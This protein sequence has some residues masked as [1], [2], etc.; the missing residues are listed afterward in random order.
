MVYQL[1]CETL[2]GDKTYGERT[3]GSCR[4]LWKVQ[5][6]GLY[7][8]P[9]GEWTLAVMVFL[10]NGSNTL[11]DS[12]VGGTFKLA[13]FRNRGLVRFQSSSE[14]GVLGTRESSSDGCDL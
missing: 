8:L 13:P 2:I 7:L 9:D 1:L 14:G 6:L 4:E 12:I 11:A 10:G 3:N 5:M